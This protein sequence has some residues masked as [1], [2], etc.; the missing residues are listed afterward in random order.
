MGLAEKMSPR[1]AVLE[2]SFREGRANARNE[3]RRSGFYR[4]V[5]G[6]LEN[7]QP[8]GGG[9]APVEKTCFPELEGIFLA[10]NWR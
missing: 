4:R 6:R 8:R 10:E 5:Y 3:C 1:A 7:G 9:R 2:F